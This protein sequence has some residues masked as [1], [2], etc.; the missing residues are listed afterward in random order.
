ME[1]YKRFDRDVFNFHLKDSMK[2]IFY[3]EGALR[4]SKDKY[5][6]KEEDKNKVFPF[7]SR[8]YK[9][10]NRKPRIFIDDIGADVE[11]RGGQYKTKKLTWFMD[12]IHQTR[13][14][15]E[16]KL[17]KDLID[18]YEDY[19]ANGKVYHG[20]THRGLDNDFKNTGELN[21]LDIPEGQKF[22]E[23]V[24]DVSD[25]CILMYTQKFGLLEHYNPGEI[26]S[27]RHY[28]P[29]NPIGVYYPIWEIHKYEKGIGH[30]ES[31]HT[32]GAHHYEYGNRIFTSMFYLNDVE[33]G[34]RTVFPFSGAGIKCE[35]GKH[36]AFPCYWPY[37][38]Y[39][40]TPE[41]DDKYILTT[42]L[43][44]MW[45]EEYMKNFSKVEGTGKAQDARKTKFIFEE[46]Q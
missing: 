21:L 22:I 20:L 7:D 16:P 2:Q 42:W 11:M 44:K 41:S 6:M 14:A 24:R 9:T 13:N 33:E 46:E 37:V 32:E 19:A 4:K 39:A 23:T 45:P 27:P 35:E 31:W 15:L 38:H 18:L 40:Q 28:D 5:D 34:G 29:D 10:T 36:L 17:C 12:S 8:M 3:P 26:T 1:Q 30:Y 25:H 43:Q